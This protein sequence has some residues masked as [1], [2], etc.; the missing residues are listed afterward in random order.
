MTYSIMIYDPIWLKKPQCVKIPLTYMM[1]TLV[2]SW[3]NLENHQ[4]GPTDNTKMQL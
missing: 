4:K 1:L 2:G 3:I